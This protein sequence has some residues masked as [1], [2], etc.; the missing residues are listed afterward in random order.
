MFDYNWNLYLYSYQG[1]LQNKMRQWLWHD[2]LNNAHFFESPFLIVHA[3]ASVSIIYV[4]CT[5][6]DQVRIFAV[7]KPFFK[8]LEKHRII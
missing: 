6:I 4:V 5:I 8:V 7:E 2:T 3:L 1:N